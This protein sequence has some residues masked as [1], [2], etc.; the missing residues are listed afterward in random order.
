M[1]QQ[2]FNQLRL[3]FPF[4]FAQEMI[5][6]LSNFWKIIFLLFH[7]QRIQWVTRLPFHFLHL[8]VLLQFAISPYFLA[9][10]EIDCHR[11]LKLFLDSL[12]L[13]EPDHRHFILSHLDNS[14]IAKEEAF[15]ISRLVIQ[16]FLG[17]FTAFILSLIFTFAII[18]EVSILS[19]EEGILASKD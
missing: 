6:N 15:F 8:M 4:Q 5:L 3:L 7:H 16:A 18:K 2:N 1:L 13:V 9:L 11:N 10:Q 19:K 14:S 17:R 12:L